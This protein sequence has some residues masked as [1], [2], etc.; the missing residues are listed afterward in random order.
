MKTIHQT[1]ASLLVFSLPLPVAEGFAASAH[2]ADRPNI[3]IL[4]SDD[5]RA[6]TIHALGN[7]HIATPNLDRL[8]REGTV[9]TRA[10][11][12]GSMQGAVCVPSR[13]ML[14]SGRTLFRVKENLQAQTTWPEVFG[15][16][17]YAT[18]MTG[19]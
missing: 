4:F 3:L 16:T 12:M 6:D 18:F 10:Y 11:C 1:V 2:A 7:D 14:L 9:C 8:V 13:A 17:G 19:K 5:Q 15:R